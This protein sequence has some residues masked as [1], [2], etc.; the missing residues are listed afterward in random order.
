MKL[1]IDQIKIKQSVFHWLLTVTLIIFLAIGYT[2]F[3]YSGIDD[4]VKEEE[5]YTEN[6]LNEFDTKMEND[7]KSHVWGVGLFRG[8]NSNSLAKH[9]LDRA[10]IQYISRRRDANGDQYVWSKDNSGAEHLFHLRK[11]TISGNV[12]PTRITDKSS[13]SL[14]VQAF[15][16][17][18]HTTSQKVSPSRT[19]KGSR[20]SGSTPGSTPSSKPT[21]GSTPSSKPTPGSTPSS[22]PT[23]GST[24][25]SKPTPGSTPSSKPTPGS[26][27]S[28]KPTPGS[29]PS[30][31]PTPGS[32]PSS[33]P[34]SA[35][36]SDTKQQQRS[37][38]ARTLIIEKKWYDPRNWVTPRKEVIGKS[39]T[40][41]KSV[42]TQKKKTFQQKKDKDSQLS[43]KWY[44]PTTWGDEQ[45]TADKKNKK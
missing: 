14:E 42:V 32:T 7:T 26:T 37:K 35:L 8:H 38:A 3:A 36:R 13:L 16:T 18:A 21:P 41:K 10:N 43:T 15:F 30:S 44:D 1:Y 19:F 6:E 2:N 4:D 29:T 24:P 28:S 20:G 9:G 22:K 12:A 39:T 33:K 40:T 27:P 25:S 17:K 11:R 5:I 45:S 23:P 34:K 31:K